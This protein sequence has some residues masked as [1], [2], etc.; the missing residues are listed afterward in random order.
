M[1]A[2][3]SPGAGE[4][5][6][7]AVAYPGQGAG[8]AKLDVVRTR[9][10]L[11]LPVLV[12][13]SLLGPGLLAGCGSDDPT[14][15]AATKASTFSAGGSAASSSSTN[16]GT[17]SNGATGALPFPGDTAADTAQPSAGARVTVKDIR[18]GRQGGFD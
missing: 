17:E 2:R 5:I 14:P 15:S 4:T 11:V 3:S 7:A 6:H 10:R 9:S 13:A 1:G 12:S 18:I 8:A 16:P